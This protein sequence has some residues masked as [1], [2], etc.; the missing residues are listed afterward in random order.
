MPWPLTG[1]YLWWTPNKWLLLTILSGIPSWFILWKSSFQRGNKSVLIDPLF[2]PLWRS[3]SMIQLMRPWWETHSIKFKTISD[4]VAFPFGISP[5]LKVS[6]ALLLGERPFSIIRELSLIWDKFPLAHNIQSPQLF[7]LLFWLLPVSF[8][9]KI[10]FRDIYC[11]LLIKRDSILEVRVI[12]SEL[13]RFWVVRLV[14]ASQ[15]LLETSRSLLL[16][17]AYIFV[18]SNQWPSLS[19]DCQLALLLL[20]FGSK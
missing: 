2:F 9:P 12:F 17:S 13:V 8:V 16:Q 20:L 18:Y 14:D 3:L 1:T 7:T 10:T 4:S 15:H 6:R 5:K 19:V 11:Y